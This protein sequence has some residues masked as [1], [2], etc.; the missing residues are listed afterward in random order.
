MIDIKKLAA[1]MSKPEHFKFVNDSQNDLEKRKRIEILKTQFDKQSGNFSSVNFSADIAD[2]GN[3]F[4]GVYDSDD[5]ATFN[6]KAKEHT[7]FNDIK[8]LTVVHLVK[9]SIKKFLLQRNSVIKANK[10]KKAE[11]DAQKKDNF[12]SHPNWF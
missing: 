7:A 5:F 2:C 12:V 11:R 8:R 6:Q 3:E 9:E 4:G 1:Y 10:A